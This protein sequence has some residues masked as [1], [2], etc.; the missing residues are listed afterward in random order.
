VGRSFAIFKI[1]ILCLFSID[2]FA[3]DE[4]CKNSASA[5]LWQLNKEP[6]A[7]NQKPTLS[8]SYIK[9]NCCVMGSEMSACNRGAEID[10]CEQAVVRGKCSPMQ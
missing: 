7:V 5:Q 10:F 6:I 9:G 8:F 3:A 2:S 4:W 1:S